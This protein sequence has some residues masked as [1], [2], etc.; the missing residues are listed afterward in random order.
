MSDSQYVKY[1]GLMFALNEHYLRYMIRLYEL[2]ERD[3]ECCLVLGEVAHHNA[4]NV[5][6]DK[7]VMVVHQDAIR[8]GLK[9]CNAYSISM[10]LGM[11][12]ET[13]R[14]KIK[15][16]EQLGFVEIDERKHIFVSRLAREKL[17]EFSKS[18]LSHFLKFVQELKADQLV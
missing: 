10:T 3:L 7:S 1:S 12:R 5:F 15:K 13:V 2:F 18:T 14:R 17:G 11:P 9:G 6:P 16:L 4:K 8:V